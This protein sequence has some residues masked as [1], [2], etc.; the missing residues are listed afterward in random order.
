MRVLFFN[1][2]AMGHFL[3][4]IPLARALRKQGHTVAFVTA[5]TMLDDVEREGFD[6]LP[7]GVTMQEGVAEVTR[8]TGKNIMDSRT[9]EL[10]AE[11]F[12]GV[13]IDLAFD[14]ALA[15]TKEWGPDLIV[16]EQVDFVGPIVATE[17]NLPIALAGIDPALETD[18]QDALVA[19][20]RP[21]YQ[22]RDL[23]A[24]VHWLTGNRFVDL[25]PPSLQRADWVP[26]IDRIALRPEPYSAPEGTP[27][28]QRA[29]GTGRPKVLVSLSTVAAAATGLDTLLRSLS[30]LDVDLVA[31]FSGRP[32]DDLGLEPGRIE[33]F[34]FLP[35]AEL[36]DGVAAVVHQ[37]GSGTTW[38]T[39]ARGVPAVIAPAAIGQFRQAKRVE[40]TGAGL[41]LPQGQ[42]DPAAVAEAL[43]RVLIEPSFTAAAHR[44]RDEIA[45]MPPADEIAKRLVN[46]I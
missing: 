22:D 13:R 39:A 16:A 38:G 27:P 3:P 43:G 5:A 29:P 19:A 23:Q 37:G 20:A 10:A 42:P 41:A 15:A 18:F 6:L 36:L 21:R 12:A 11:F 40:A 33:L 9:P 34:S 32:I 45:A 46:S 14:D 26:P 1:N 8:R 4:L 17:L 28:A 24:P 44:L 7:A 35:A 2:P 31:T 30:T 25:C